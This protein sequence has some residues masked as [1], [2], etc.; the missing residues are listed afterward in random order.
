[1]ALSIKDEEKK[2]DE[3][4]EL[5]L[6]ECKYKFNIETVLS[7]LKELKS[8]TSVSSITIDGNWHR[9]SEK[10]HQVFFFDIDVDIERKNTT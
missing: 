3:S 4:N 8:N 5:S 10:E 9:W 7:F 2:S 6:V 1:M